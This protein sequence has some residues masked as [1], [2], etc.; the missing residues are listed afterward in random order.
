MQ[1]RNPA[2]N[3]GIRRLRVRISKKVVRA[4][5]PAAIAGVLK[6]GNTTSYGFWSCFL[7]SRSP[8]NSLRVSARI[9]LFSSITFCRCSL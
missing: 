2:E 1:R 4:C 9:C 6:S 5:P 7:C 3:A 8:A